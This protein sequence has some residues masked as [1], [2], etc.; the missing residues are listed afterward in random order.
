ME[1]LVGIVIVRYVFNYT[2]ACLRWIYGS[3]WRTVAKKPTFTFSEYLNGPK[4]SSDY[5]DEFAHGTNNIILGL[6]FFFIA[7]MVIIK[8]NI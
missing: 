8:Y 4:Q 6:V 2:G 3:I 7:A 1:D 5:Y